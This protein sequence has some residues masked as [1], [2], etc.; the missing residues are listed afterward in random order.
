MITEHLAE[1]VAGNY[2]AEGRPAGIE[3]ANET[4]T[5]YALRGGLGK[6]RLAAKAATC[7]H[8]L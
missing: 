4:R 7:Q 6:L 3:A 1:G 8:I 5:H 2:D